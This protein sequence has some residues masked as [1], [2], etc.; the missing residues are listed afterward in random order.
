[1]VMAFMIWLLGKWGVAPTPEQIDNMD[2]AFR[3]RNHHAMLD[4]GGT[5]FD[6]SRWT[7]DDFEKLMTIGLGYEYL[8]E[9]KYNGVG[10]EV[11][12]QILGPILRPD[13]ERHEY[14]VGGG[15]A[16]YPI[17]H[18]RIFMHAGLRIKSNGDVEAAG[19]L[20]VGYRIMFFGVGVQ[21][22][23]YVQTTVSATTSWL[24]GC[25]FEY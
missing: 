5:R 22:F 14:F 1:M 18:Q 17:R 13:R 9:R 15:L 4:F 24:L 25:R 20:G 3:E 16:Y 23:A 19:R 8:V 12:G 10:F 11:Q 2:R 21:P 6:G 7:G